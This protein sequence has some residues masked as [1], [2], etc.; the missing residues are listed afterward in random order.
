MTPERWE[1]VDVIFQEAIELPP[2]QREDFVLQTCGG[3]DEL[4][5]EVQSLL[6]H[7]V[8]DSFLKV[9]IQ[10]AARS[11][12]RDADARAGQR[13]GVYRIN[14]LIGHGGMGAVR[15]W[16]DGIQPSAEQRADHRANRPEAPGLEQSNEV[17]HGGRRK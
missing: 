6:A 13:I 2:V 5:A 12:T 10:G 14:R 17:V 8:E 4:R 16:S 7:E 15:W 1:K 3:D 11:L 9:P